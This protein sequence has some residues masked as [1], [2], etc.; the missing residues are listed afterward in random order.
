SGTGKGRA[1][2]SAAAAVAA[3][4]AAESSMSRPPVPVETFGSGTQSSSAIPQQQQPSTAKTSARSSRAKRQRIDQSGHAGEA[5]SVEGLD[6]DGI[7]IEEEQAAASK[8]RRKYNRRAKTGEDTATMVVEDGSELKDVVQ[9]VSSS[10]G[11]RSKSGS[12]TVVTAPAAP[13]AVV[14]QDD[15]ELLDMGIDMNM[16]S[17]MDMSPDTDVEDL[18]DNSNMNDD[19]TSVVIPH[20]RQQVHSVGSS[21]TV[22][23]GASDAVMDGAVVAQM[24]MLSKVYANDHSSMAM[25]A[26]EQQQRQ[27]QQ[28]QQQ[29]QQH[30]QQKSRQRSTRLQQQHQQPATNELFSGVTFPTPKTHKS[31]V[32]PHTSAVPVQSSTSQNTTTGHS[33]ASA[34]MTMSTA[35]PS[36]HQQQ[37]PILTGLGLSGTNVTSNPV[38]SPPPPRTHQLRIPAPT[39]ASRAALSL[40]I[41]DP[42]AAA[43]QPEPPIDFTE[44]AQC[45]YTLRLFMHQQKFSQNQIDQ[46]HA[47]YLTLDVKRKERLQQGQGQSQSQQGSVQE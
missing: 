39:T 17:H 3:A 42:I 23:R 1:A 43:F 47:I 35:V 16:D 30:Q 32:P 24:D 7:N 15:Q 11:R 20:Q 29:Q 4:A 34:A 5:E 26:V 13:A 21:S 19:G 27:Q 22:G 18:N 44:A 41:Q 36:S 12:S 28:R 33:I 45:V 10:R 6:I 25:T 37:Q 38:G 2:R 31:A 46:L 8:P 14:Q 9:P 40:S